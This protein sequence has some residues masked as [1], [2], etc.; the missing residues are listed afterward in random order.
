MISGSGSADRRPQRARATT[1]RNEKKPPTC[2]RTVL[3]VCA[4][5]H[6]P[7]CVLAQGEESRRAGKLVAAMG[8][9]KSRARARRIYVAARAISIADL[10]TCVALRAPLRTSSRFT[11]G[12]HQKTAIFLCELICCIQIRR[13]MPWVTDNSS[14]C[15]F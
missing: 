13:I 6:N 15:F 1:A 8:I 7:V 4:L 2:A 11:R 3:S 14:K 10:S 12:G 5:A 9:R